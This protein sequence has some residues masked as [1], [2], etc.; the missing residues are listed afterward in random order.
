MI[1]TVGGFFK[2]KK[3]TVANR[4]K[5]GEKNNVVDITNKV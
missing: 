5:V 2:K 4:H 3:D 1:N